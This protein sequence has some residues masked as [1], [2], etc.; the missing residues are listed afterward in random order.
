MKEI[1]D[2][3]HVVDGFKLII[4]NKFIIYNKNHIFYIYL[5]LFSLF[6]NLLSYFLL[7]E[8]LWLCLQH[9]LM[10]SLPQTYI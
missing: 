7:R 6:Y 8:C 3:I 2:K 10:M 5:V 9:H 1:I 4:Y